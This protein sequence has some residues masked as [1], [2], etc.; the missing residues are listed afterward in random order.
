MKNAEASITPDTPLG[1]GI[2]F[3]V[4]RIMGRRILD[5]N[6]FGSMVFRAQI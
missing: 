3:R 5:L 1:K 4:L 6:K 2:S